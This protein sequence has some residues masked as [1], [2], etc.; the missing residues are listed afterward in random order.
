ME[1][2]A[3][4]LR[5]GRQAAIIAGAAG[6]QSNPIS[7]PCTNFGYLFVFAP[8]PTIDRSWHLPRRARTR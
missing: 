7:Q 5:G 4:D 2:D 6:S 1:P 3:V 8:Y